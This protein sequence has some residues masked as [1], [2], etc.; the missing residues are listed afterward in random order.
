MEADQDP[1]EVVEEPATVAAT[2]ESPPKACRQNVSF[3][4]G[5][6]ILSMRPH[7]YL[8]QDDLPTVWDWRNIN[9]KNYVT[10]DKN[11]HIPE[12]CGSCWAQGTTSALSD[13]IS[14]LRKGKIQDK[15][16]NLF[17]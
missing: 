8:D 3:Q 1:V 11:Q 13:R 9:G 2:P 12:Y 14:I 4:N 6:K 15:N 5:E 16:H 17:F 7:E 10:W